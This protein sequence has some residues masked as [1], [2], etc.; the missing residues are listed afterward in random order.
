MQNGSAASNLNVIGM[1][2]QAQYPQGRGRVL[3]KFSGSM[4]L[5]REIR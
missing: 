2:A 3:G 5:R 1:R 4:T